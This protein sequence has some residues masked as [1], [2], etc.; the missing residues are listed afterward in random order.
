MHVAMRDTFLI[1]PAG[2]VVKTWEV[3]DI[4]GHSDDVLATIQAMK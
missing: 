2:K 4:Q 3:K 1:S